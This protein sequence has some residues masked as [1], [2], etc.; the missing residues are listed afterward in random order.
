MNVGFTSPRWPRLYLWFAA[1]APGLHRALPPPPSGVSSNCIFKP[2]T[3]NKLL[4]LGESK[5][6]NV[7]INGKQRG[8]EVIN[9][10]AQ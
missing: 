4:R 7:E 8:L 1:P 6:S 9:S 5:W 3:H 10:L 2:M